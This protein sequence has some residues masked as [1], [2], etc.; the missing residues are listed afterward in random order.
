MVTMDQTI[1]M[2]GV[3]SQQQNL[4]EKGNTENEINSKQ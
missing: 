2:A 4:K 1:E 3:G